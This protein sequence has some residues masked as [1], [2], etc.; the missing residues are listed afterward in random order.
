M[1]NINF[2][3]ALNKWNSYKKLNDDG[4][5]KCLLLTFLHAAYYNLPCL[6]YSWHTYHLN[7]QT[8]NKQII[9]AIVP[10]SFASYRYI[11]CYF[12]YFIIT[13]TGDWY[14]ISSKLDF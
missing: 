5:E 4:N 2:H 3:L 12:E 1:I 14:D 13:H 11:K 7:I 6:M 8:K 10:I 9:P